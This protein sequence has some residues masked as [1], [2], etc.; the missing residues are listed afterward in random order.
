MGLKWKDVDLD[1]KI[2][3]FRDA[4]NGEHRSAPLSDALSDCLYK[5]KRLRSIP[6]E[7]GFPSIIL[8]YARSLITTQS[9]DKGKKKETMNREEC[10]QKYILSFDE[11]CLHIYSKISF[12]FF[13]EKFHFR[14]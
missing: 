8:S 14:S 7:Y 1:R 6:S 10:V 12:H 4:K 13:V 2:A 11:D 9:V 3:R 5:E